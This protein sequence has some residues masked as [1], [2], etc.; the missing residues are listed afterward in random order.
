[1]AVVVVAVLVAAAGTGFKVV[2]VVQVACRSS[3]T[4]S[5]MPAMALNLV[6]QSTQ[7]P[8]HPPLQRRQHVH[9]VL[10]LAA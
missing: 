5:L 8:R 3:A 9:L 1:V 10:A 2:L 7:L 6:H 4:D